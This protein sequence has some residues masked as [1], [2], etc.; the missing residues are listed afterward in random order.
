MPVSFEDSSYDVNNI[1]Y[2]SR[3]IGKSKQRLYDIYSI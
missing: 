1:N 3:E 2:I